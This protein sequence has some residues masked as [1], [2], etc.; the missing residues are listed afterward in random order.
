MQALLQSHHTS[1]GFYRCHCA[2]HC[3][4]V[5]KSLS[6]PLGSSRGAH[7][8]YCNNELVSSSITPT[9]IFLQ[10]FGVAKERMLWLTPCSS[11]DNRILESAEA[12]LKV[13]L[14]AHLRQPVLSRGFSKRRK[15][16]QALTSSWFTIQGPLYRAFG[17]VMLIKDE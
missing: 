11:P 14:P 13:L 5:R 10:G 15:R 9:K 17:A 4:R 12:L 7:A 1:C 2:H 16:A 3:R 6:H 8:S